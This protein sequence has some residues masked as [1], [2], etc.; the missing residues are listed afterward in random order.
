MRD[1]ERCLSVC[2]SIEAAAIEA[3]VI[4]LGRR[5]PM[6]YGRMCSE[7]GRGGQAGRRAGG[8]TAAH[9]MVHPTITSPCDAKD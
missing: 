7:S 6:I 1:S 9:I 8:Q 4:G 5:W 3:A 2:P